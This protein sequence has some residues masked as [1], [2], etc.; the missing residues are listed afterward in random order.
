MHGS[1]ERVLVVDDDHHARF[2]L[3]A[4]LDHAG[5]TVVPACDGRAA[6]TELHKRRFDAVVTDYRMPFLNGIEL[7]RLIQI[8]YPHVPVILASGSL[9]LPDEPILSDCRPFGWLRKP[10][11]TSSVLE[12]VRSAMDRQSVVCKD[13]VNITR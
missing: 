9:P 6:L 7:L 2:L 10:Y 4:L 12:L 3:G 5:Y 8:H 13:V 11:D 1:G